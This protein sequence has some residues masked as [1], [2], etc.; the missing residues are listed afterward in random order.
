MT[1][2]ERQLSRRFSQWIRPGLLVGVIGLSVIF[3]QWTKW[4]VTRS[5]HTGE[6][7]PV[8]S[9][10]FNLT[11]VKNTGAAFGILASADPA[12]RTPLFIV[13]PV[14]A[15]FVIVWILRQVPENEIRMP[16]ALSLVAGG[17]IG[18]LIDR[19]V[20]GYVV[21]FLDF[22]W[23]YEVHF[24]AFNVA[25]TAISVGVFFMLLDVYMRKEEI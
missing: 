5:F 12:L 6:S 13:V 1:G 17:A 25:D 21:D 3:D 15:I 11:F 20:Y 24:P 14:L 19:L 7:V 23:K 8:L 9:G 10:F 2:P 22:H 18:N 16:L 4:L